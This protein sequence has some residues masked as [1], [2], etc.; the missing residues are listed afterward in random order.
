V[1]MV[2]HI[3]DRMPKDG[4]GPIAMCGAKVEGL[5]VKRRSDSPHFQGH[6]CAACYVTLTDSGDAGRRAPST[7]PRRAQSPKLRE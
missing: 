2:I 3:V 1:S 7:G 6:L 5:Y 4:T